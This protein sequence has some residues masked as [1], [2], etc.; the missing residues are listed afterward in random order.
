MLT[1]YVLFL[2]MKRDKICS[3]VR[4]TVNIHVNLNFFFK[5]IHHE[6]LSQ[7]DCIYNKNNFYNIISVK[8]LTFL[9]PN[10]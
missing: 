4:R 3:A 9:I 6:Q 5:E 2:K 1:N 10:F 8:N 7:N